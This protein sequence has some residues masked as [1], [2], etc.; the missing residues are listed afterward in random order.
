MKT[1][2]KGALWALTILGLTLMSSSL[3]IA[4]AVAP[5]ALA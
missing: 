2:H 3:T 1:T 5:F 4:S